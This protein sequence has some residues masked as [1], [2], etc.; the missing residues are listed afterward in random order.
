MSSM[1]YIDHPAPEVTA[2]TLVEGP[3]PEPAAGEVLIKVSHFGI[4]RPDVMQRLGLYPPPADASPVLGLELSGEIVALGEGVSQWQLGDKV[5]ALANGGAY[6]EFCAVPEGQCLPI[7]A[8]LSMAEAASLPEVMFTVWT[9]VFM[10][11]HLQPGET[12]LVHAGA[13]GIGSAAIQMASAMGCRVITTASSDEKC[14]Y[15]R[16]LGADEAINYQRE[17]FVEV[18]KKLTDK[19]GADVILDMVGGDYVAR[20]IACA[21][22][23]GRVVNIAFLRGSQVE[24]N[25][26]PVLLKRLTLGGSTLRPRT[27]EHKAKIA[28]QLAQHIWPLIE[29]KRIVPTVA[30]CLPWQRVAEAHAAMESNALL[31]K[32]VLEVTP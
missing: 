31:G 30:L 14:Q 4:N 18:V 5:C 25:L 19:R 20:N 29:A 22:F 16:D 2:L 6:A 10:D 9:N 17:D 28:Q 3:R 26:M 12:F 1:R 21:A 8:G 7:P 11:A 15:C 24:V 27:A 32:A 23:D 13:S